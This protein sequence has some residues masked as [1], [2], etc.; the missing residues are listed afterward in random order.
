MASCRTSGRSN[1]TPAAAIR[2]GQPIRLEISITD[3]DLVKDLRQQMSD[4]SVRMEELQARADRAEY[5][6]RCASILNMRLT[7]WLREEHIRIP[8]EIAQVKDLD[9]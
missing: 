2:S 5:R 1:R 4:L 6:Y 3:S 7:D 8:R 9:L